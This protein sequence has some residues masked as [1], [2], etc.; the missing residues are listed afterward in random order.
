MTS[1]ETVRCAETGPK[2][3]K[4]YRGGNLALAEKFD[5]FLGAQ[6]YSPH[7]RRA[8]KRVVAD[9]CDF[10]R[11]EP[12]TEVDRTV[13]RQYLAYLSSR[14]ASPQTIAR[15][16]YA[17]KSFFEFLDRAG[18]VDISPARL[19]RNRRLPK[20]LPRFLTEQEMD[21]FLVAAVDPRDKAAYG[22][23][24]RVAE[25]ASIHL[26][27]IDFHHRTI[28]V[29]G[30]GNKEG[31]VYF[32]PPAARAIK[33]Y[34]RGR[35]TSFLFESDGI[36]PQ[37]GSVVLCTDGR[38]RSKYW[39]GR[40]YEYREGGGKVKRV[41][42]SKYLGTASKIR[43]KER[44]WRRFKALV[45]VPTVRPKPPG[46]LGVR[47]LR[48]TIYRV[49]KQAGLGRINPHALRHSFATHLLDR[50]ADLMYVKEP[51]RHENVS[52]TAIYLQTSTVSLRRVYDRCHPRS[53]KGKHGA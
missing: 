22:T 49:A 46:P 19:I 15:E 36:P 38:R 18:V 34:L 3:V 52:T 42:R 11:S 25:L 4:S 13:I 12:V 8:Y 14:G 29:L 26:E 27:N 24:C 39:S 41:L 6:G 20:R 50:G 21:R 53:G 23:G 51:L 32:G 28:R 16:L 31:M 5:S 1:T 9:F 10:I 17:I 30:K 47:N 2:P 33:K 7:T 37:Q 45:K 44:A 40:W 35:T 43:T 48:N